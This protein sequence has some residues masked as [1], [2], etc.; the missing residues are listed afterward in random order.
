MSELEGYYSGES[1]MESTRINATVRECLE[2]CDRSLQPQ[3]CLENYTAWLRT[4]PGWEET[5][6]REFEIRAKRMLG[7]LLNA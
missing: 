3:E 5:E 4:D 6:V 1:R 2:A 7:E